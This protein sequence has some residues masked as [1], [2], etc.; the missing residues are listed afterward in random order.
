MCAE[1]T[2]ASGH[3]VNKSVG[4]GSQNL[5]DGRAM[6]LLYLTHLENW[7]G[8]RLICVSSSVSVSSKVAGD[9]DVQRIVRVAGYKRFIQTQR[10]PFTHTPCTN[11]LCHGL[12]QPPRNPNG[13]VSDRR[14]KADG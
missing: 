8:W 10:Y 2:V 12:N 1:L 13:H 3:F 7:R 6:F 14:G 9:N 11:S 4:L 5:V